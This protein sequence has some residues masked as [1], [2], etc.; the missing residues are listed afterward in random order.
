MPSAAR[1]YSVNSTLPSSVVAPK[2]TARAASRSLKL[3]H[4]VFGTLAVLAFSSAWFVAS[5]GAEIDSLNY[6]NVDM[7]MKIQT[8]AADNASLTAERNQLST[9]SR[10]LN[11]A[12]SFGMLQGNT[13]QIPGTQSGK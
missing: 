3:S 10:I 5:K 11:A 8:Y 13:L 9:P 4:F 12:L 7:Q 1:E 6:Q 2:P